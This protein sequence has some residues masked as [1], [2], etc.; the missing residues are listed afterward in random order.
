MAARRRNMGQK[1]DGTGT[2]LPR[3]RAAAPDDHLDPN[4]KAHRMTI[5]ALLASNE[6]HEAK[7]IC[8]KLALAAPGSIA[9]AATTLRE[10]PECTWRTT[11]DVVLLECSQQTGREAVSLLLKLARSSARSRLLVLRRSF[12]A[13][14]T[15]S[16]MQHGASGCLLTS[17]DTAV[18]V[19]AL[20]S[21]HAG[22]AWFG[23]GDLLR[24]VRLHL[25]RGD[26]EDR[27]S[28]TPREREILDLTGSGLSNK[29][30]ARRLAISDQTVKTHLHNVYV[31]LN[32]SGRVR[33]FVALAPPRGASSS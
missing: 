19:Q 22:Q 10:A 9:A 15:L 18:Y 20:T 5:R 13:E 16:F 8:T 1:R 7:A 28:L 26:L 31:K 12:T 27:Q 25:P 23:R 11:P 21:V 33:A 24:A 6:P 4:P 17:S 30:I 3:N 29:E 2:I 14:A 32:R